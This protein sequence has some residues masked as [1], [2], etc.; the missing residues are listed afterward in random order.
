MF[1]GRCDCGPCTHVNVSQHPCPSNA[2]SQLAYI[3]HPVARSFSLR[4]GLIGARYSRIHALEREESKNFCSRSEINWE[5][6][7]TIWL[8]GN[9]WIS[10]ENFGLW[11]N[12]SSHQTV[13][14][15]PQTPPSYPPHPPDSATPSP[16]SPPPSHLPTTLH[17][18]H[19]P[20]R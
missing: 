9:L 10:F 6:L 4:N 16:F 11:P 7:S 1:L 12:R 17:T 13:Q 18:A 3:H 8:T 15:S 5:I 14:T 2:P 20:P 19:T